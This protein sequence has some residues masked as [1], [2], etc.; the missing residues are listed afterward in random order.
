MELN[1]H[2]HWSDYWQRGDA[3]ACTREFSADA[4]TIIASNWKRHF[5]QLESGARLLDLATGN[6]ALPTYLADTLPLGVRDIEAVGVDLATIEKTAPKFVRP[7]ARVSMEFR[8]KVDIADLPFEDDEF[9]LVTSQ[10]GIEYADLPKA[11][12]EACRVTRGRLVLLMHASEGV[13]V[14]QNADIVRQIRLVTDELRMVDLVRQYLVKPDHDGR[15]LLLQAFEQLQ[16][17]IAT[18][19]NP[20]FLRTFQQQLKQ[21][22]D[23]LHTYPATTVTAVIDEFEERLSNHADRM[24]SLESAAVTAQELQTILHRQIPSEMQAQDIKPLYSDEGAHLI[25]YW[26]EAWRV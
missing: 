7:D 21:I 24:A 4:R 12:A 26:V 2:D 3:H 17:E 5:G 14:R 20:S 19:E 13:V 23:S 25:G 15:T 9:D 16:S 18:V 1:C 22:C 6:G 11:L 8:G 10:Y